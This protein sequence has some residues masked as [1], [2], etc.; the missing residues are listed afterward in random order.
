MHLGQQMSLEQ[1]ASTCARPLGAGAQPYRF[2]GVAMRATN[3]GGRAGDV[4]WASHCEGRPAY[5][6]TR[7]PPLRVALGRAERRPLAPDAAWQNDSPRAN[8]DV[9][10]GAAEAGIP[11]SVIGWPGRDVILPRPPGGE[12]W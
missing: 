2:A 10:G 12:R 11:S 3:L 6:P 9:K 8:D 7:P 4:S 5:G 1:A